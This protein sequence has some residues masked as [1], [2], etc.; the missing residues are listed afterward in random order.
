MENV[1]TFKLAAINVQPLKVLILRRPQHDNHI[2][3]VSSSNSIKRQV[4]ALLDK[5]PLLH[6]KQICK[7]LNLNHALKG[8]YIRHIKHNWK[9]DSERQRGLKCSSHA[10]RGW[11]FLP[12]VVS[13]GFRARAVKGGWVPT[14]ARNKWLLWRDKIGRLQLFTTGRLN[15]WV[16]KPVTPGRVYQIVC[17]GLSWTGLVTDLKVLEGILKGI[18]FKGAHY[19]FD[20]TQPLPRLTIDLFSKSNGIVIKVGDRS[21]PNSVEIIAHYPDWGEKT[22]QLLNKFMRVLARGDLNPLIPK[23]LERD[24]AR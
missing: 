18:R 12:F 10:W 5:N 7:L 8:D 4:Y 21:H 24:Y 14:R 1:K 3:H 23:P 13:E 17:N 20:T 19:V 22:E 15:I 9:Y 2:N 11:S 16:R 6:A